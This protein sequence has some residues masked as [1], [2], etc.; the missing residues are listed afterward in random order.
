MKQCTHCG[1][2]YPDEATVCGIDAM[3]LKFVSLPEWVSEHEKIITAEHI[4]L[5]AIFHWIFGW[6]GFGRGSAGMDLLLV[7][8]KLGS[9]KGRMVS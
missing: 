1:K 6:I 5:L 4:R 9:K 7:V 2:Q 8:S 3:P